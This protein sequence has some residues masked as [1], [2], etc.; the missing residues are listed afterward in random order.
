MSYFN[1][2]GLCSF[3][4]KSKNLKHEIIGYLFPLI[5]IIQ[6]QFVDIKTFMT[7]VQTIL[8]N[9][10]VSRKLG[11]ALKQD[12]QPNGLIKINLDLVTLETISFLIGCSFTHEENN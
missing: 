12:F 6:T 10:P 8:Q 11:R 7:I 5:R 2:I 4:K 1:E 9:K 3:T